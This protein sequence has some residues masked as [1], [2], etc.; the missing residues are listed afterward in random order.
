M[1]GPPP[2]RLTNTWSIP[3]LQH[4]SNTAN[5][6]IDMDMTSYP[7]LYPTSEY[8]TSDTGSTTMTPPPLFT[9]VPVAS[10]SRSLSPTTYM[11]NLQLEP[12][13]PHTPTPRQFR[14]FSQSE[15]SSHFSRAPPTRQKKA[16]QQPQPTA[17]PSTLFQ[18]NQPFPSPSFLTQSHR[19]LITGQTPPLPRRTFSKQMPDPPLPVP[20]AGTITLGDPRESP[21]AKKVFEYFPTA[22]ELARKAK[23]S[24]PGPLPALPSICKRLDLF[25]AKGCRPPMTMTEIVERLMTITKLDIDCPSNPRGQG[26]PKRPMNIFFCFQQFRRHA[27][28]AMFP[29]L[30][31]GEVSTWMAGERAV[32][33]GLESDEFAYWEDLHRSYS[34][35]FWKEFPLYTFKKTASKKKKGFGSGKTQPIGELRKKSSTMN[36]KER[37]VGRSIS[38]I[39]LKS[40]P[41]RQSSPLSTHSVESFDSTIYDPSADLLAYNALGIDVPR[42]SQSIVTDTSSLPQQQIFDD[43]IINAPALGAAA[44]VYGWTPTSVSQSLP[45]MMPASTPA[46]MPLYT[47]LQEAPEFVSRPHSADIH[48]DIGARADL[49]F[50]STFVLS[51]N[52]ND[53]NTISKSLRP[54]HILIRGSS[55]KSYFNEGS[56]PITT[57]ITPLTPIGQA[58]RMSNPNLDAHFVHPPYPSVP[59]TYDHHQ[60]PATSI[61]SYQGEQLQ[62]NILRSHSY[63]PNMSYNQLTTSYFTPY[64]LLGEHDDQT[65]NQS[66]DQIP[67]QMIDNGYIG[68]SADDGALYGTMPVSHELPHPGNYA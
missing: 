44:T 45:A 24:V 55:Y 15:Y 48:Q 47:P 56:F 63:S 13:T 53:N 16:I 1:K 65:Q 11:G 8:P 43:Y 18:L 33:E 42:R 22:R 50:G 17:S 57:P 35:Q 5:A 34:A 49:T 68:V 37:V 31:T 40:M 36:L 54:P 64:P 61:L 38:V 32:I 2:P 4:P 46:G 9:T 27:V 60:S 6:D 39:S 28:T 29:D 3:Q 59:I 66:Q 14:T 12:Y 25:C 52:N 20:A 21:W 19:P 26:V 41:R 51:S 7:Q 58:Q 30:T 23:K 62:Y 10:S 67:R